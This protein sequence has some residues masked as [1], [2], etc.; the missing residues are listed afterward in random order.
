MQTSVTR[1]AYVDIV[2]TEYEKDEICAYRVGRYVGITR[3]QHA[4]SN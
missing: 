3:N 2:K 1:T 4:T